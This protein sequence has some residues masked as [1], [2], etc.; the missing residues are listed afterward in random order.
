MLIQILLFII[1]IGLIF[2]GSDYF[3]DASVAIGKHARLPQ[4]VV[5][6]TI[7]SVATTSPELT[8]SIISGVNRV[9]GLAV[10]NAL[11]SV[12]ANIGL[13]L[14]LAAIIKPFKLPQGKF[15]GRVLIILGL[16]FLLF[17]FTID[18]NLSRWRGLILVIV[19]ILYLILDYHRGQ[20]QYIT[21]N[22][23]LND[24][25]TSK[26]NSKR[27]IALYFVLGLAMVIVGSN[28]L[29]NSASTIAKALGIPSLFIGLTIVSIGTSL[30]E[31]A[32]A[33]A[34][35]RKNAF[36]LSVGNLVG[37]N[38]LNLTLVTGA[39]A[40]ISPLTLSRMN[41]M[42]TFPL[43]IA[44]LAV[45]F[46]SVRS[47]NEVTRREGIILLAVYTCLITGSIILNAG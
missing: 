34:A 46:F 44:I 2:K 45:F 12:A 42:F 33:I 8:V 27:T 39:A 23:N 36:D 31:L 5:G 43:V 25:T 16:T 24:S 4:L 40:S 7:V 30:P 1:G 28:L 9:P 22:N 41:Q 13:I 18:L 35:V 15:Q 29:V 37:A 20:K 21:A 32:T 10:G 38:T 14:A 26:L 6:G 19:G 47:N 3:V 17:I 11:G